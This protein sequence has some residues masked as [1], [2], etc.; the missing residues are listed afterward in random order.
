MISLIIVATFIGNLG[1][2]WNQLKIEL[3]VNVNTLGVVPLQAN[4][5][6][7]QVVN[8]RD[9]EEKMV[10]GSHATIESYPH[11]VSLSEEGSYNC[12]RSISTETK[13][14]TAAHCLKLY[15]NSNMSVYGVHHFGWFDIPHGPRK[16]PRE[17]RKP[18]HS[19]SMACSC[20]WTRW[21]WNSVSDW[22]TGIWPHHPSIRLPP[23]NGSVPYG[24]GAPMAGWGLTDNDDI[25][26]LPNILH[27]NHTNILI[28]RNEECNR[29]SSYNGSVSVDQFCAGP[30]EGGHGICKGGSG[31]PLGL[32]VDGV[33]YGIVTGYHG[34]GLANFPGVFVRVPF[35]ANWIRSITWK[36]VFRF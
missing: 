20:R 22:S 31:S 8:I 34:C 21:R 23:Q 13:I 6:P 7:W 14:L 24:V 4:A 19:S 11:L 16:R 35:F 25:T 33:Q 18:W 15:P 17:T 3:Y 10:G 30:M 28:L 26:A 2:L 32:F 5:S 36:E 29:P 1:N 12:G 27:Y 9:L